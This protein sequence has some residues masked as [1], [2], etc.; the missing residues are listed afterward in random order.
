MDSAL[1][2]FYQLCKVHLTM[3]GNTPRRLGLLATE[4]RERLEKCWEEDIDWDLYPVQLKEVNNCQCNIYISGLNIGA[5]SNWRCF[6]CTTYRSTSISYQLVWVHN[7]SFNCGSKRY[8]VERTS[9]DMGMCLHVH[10]CRKVSTML[11]H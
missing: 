10:W 6:K 1:Q 11:I 8:R 9:A 5:S 3:A 4:T 7:L 2:T